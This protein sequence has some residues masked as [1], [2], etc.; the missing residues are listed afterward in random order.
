MKVLRKGWKPQKECQSCTALLELEIGDIRLSIC[1]R[2]EALRRKEPP[3]LEQLLEER[4]GAWPR[5]FAQFF[6]TCVEC[7]G[8][9]PLEYDELPARMKEKGGKDFYRQF[10]SPWEYIE[11]DDPFA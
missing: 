10:P 2:N 11:D 7:G 6:C 8:R 4:S 5:D 1:L 3:N 9:I